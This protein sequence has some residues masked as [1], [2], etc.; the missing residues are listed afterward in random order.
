M[1]RTSFY[2]GVLWNGVGVIDGAVEVLQELRKSVRIFFQ[3]YLWKRRNLGYTQNHIYRKD[4]NFCEHY[5]KDQQCSGERGAGTK[6]IYNRGG[7]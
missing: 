4:S 3:Q 2:L 1:V 7:G 6:A 5:S